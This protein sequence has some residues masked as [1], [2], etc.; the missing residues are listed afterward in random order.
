MAAEGRKRLQIAGMD[1]R[2][3]LRATTFATFPHAFSS[4][5]QAPQ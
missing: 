2:W 1:L 3:K 5:G 4:R